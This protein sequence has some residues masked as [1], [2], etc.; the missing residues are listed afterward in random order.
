MTRLSSLH[1][2]AAIIN[3]THKRNMI[4]GYVR[5]SKG[6]LAI[7]DQRRALE[8]A[9]CTLIV[10]EDPEEK[11]RPELDRLVGTL[12]AGDV[13]AVSSLDR[14]APSLPQLLTTLAVLSEKGA[15]VW[16]LKE[17]IDTGRFG[18]LA[19]DLSGLLR[20]LLA[21]ESGMLVERIQEG[22]ANV[23]RKG[24]KL[25]RRSKL[26][27]DQVAHARSLL[28]LGEGG[29]AVARTFSVSEATLYRA[30][31]HHPRGT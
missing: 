12:H 17:Q 27:T 18:E 8:A 2:L 25:G 16:S 19:G 6:A 20:G 28:E 7:A 31:R 11:G 29:R 9:D 21:A 1:Y 23:M 22:R 5:S 4:C 24:A 15:H 30:L 14:L 10:E 26:S 3:N 13:V